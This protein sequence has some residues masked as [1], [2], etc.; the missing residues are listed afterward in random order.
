MIH[1]AS[2]QSW[3]FRCRDTHH[4]VMLAVEEIGRIPR[5]HLTRHKAVGALKLGVGPLPA[6]T[7][8][9]MK[10]FAGSVSNRV[11]RSG[12]SSNTLKDVEGLTG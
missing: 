5:I 12:I 8:V 3:S 1:R 10:R 2:R 4:N 11:D 6:S 7:I 9:P